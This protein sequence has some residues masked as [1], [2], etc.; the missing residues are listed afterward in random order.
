MHTEEVHLRSLYLYLGCARAVEEFQGR[1][2]TT[3]PADTPATEQARC[4]VLRRE[5][6][7]LFRYWTTREIWNR[8]EAEQHDAKSLNLRLLRLFTEGFRLP[9]DGSGLRYAE[10]MTPAEEVHELSYR[11]TNALGMSHPPLLEM[12]HSGILPWRDMVMRRTRDA[13]DFPLEKVRQSVRE[14]MAKVE[15]SIASEDPGR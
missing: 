2:L 1:L 7:M 8:L 14:W 13:L 12:L 4:R 5:L 11:I 3:L 10:L 15:D 9:R 6:G